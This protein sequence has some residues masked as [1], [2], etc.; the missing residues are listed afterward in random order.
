VHTAGTGTEALAVWER[1]RECIDL[2][3]TDMMLPDALSGADI[4]RRLREESPALRILF[5]SGFSADFV[6][7]KVVLM[8]GVNFLPKPYP[9]AKLIRLVRENLDREPLAVAV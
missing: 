2:L 1:E 6:S 8:P 4:A 3:V 9:P 7:G 5:T